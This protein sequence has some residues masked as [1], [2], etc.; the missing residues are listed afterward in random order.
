MVFPYAWQDTDSLTI[1]LPAG[2]RLEDAES[3]GSIDF[4]QPGSYKLAMSKHGDELVC[5]RELIFGKDAF[6]SF[7][8]ANYAP[9]KRVFDEI[10]R[11]DDVTLS[12]RQAP[13]AG[14][15]Q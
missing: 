4:G 2:F 7:A 15:T 5:T 12:L 6:I 1:H 13:A 8:R 10:H 3:P 14:G 9:V 11:R